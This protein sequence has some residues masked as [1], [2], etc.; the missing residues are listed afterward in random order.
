MS[1]IEEDKIVLSAMGLSVI[2]LGIESTPPEEL[3]KLI[4]KAYHQTDVER[5]LQAIANE[6]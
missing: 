4:V 1:H 5:L 3:A 6:I 2:R